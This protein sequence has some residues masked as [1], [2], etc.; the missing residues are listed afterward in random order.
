MTPAAKHR[1]L[2]PARAVKAGASTIITAP[3]VLWGLA[4]LGV[5]LPADPATAA[6]VGAA[7]AAAMNSGL[8]YLTRGGREGEAD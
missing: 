6:A 5:G 1:N 8:Q 2:R 4:A 3:V 7:I